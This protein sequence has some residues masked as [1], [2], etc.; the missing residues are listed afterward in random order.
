M[1]E[2]NVFYFPNQDLAGRGGGGGV[3]LIERPGMSK[4]LYD[5]GGGRWEI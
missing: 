4:L 2:K 3:L 1:N 5:V